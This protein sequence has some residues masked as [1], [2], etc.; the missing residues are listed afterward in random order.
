MVNFLL[1]LQC[2]MGHFGAFCGVRGNGR[3]VFSL[4][5]ISFKLSGNLPH[6]SLYFLSDIHGDTFNRKVKIGYK[7]R[8]ISFII[9]YEI[10]GSR[11]SLLPRPGYLDSVIHHGGVEVPCPRR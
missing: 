2:K 9:S 11:S 6:G 3:R 8:S 7:V 4:G 1:V 5:P 10:M